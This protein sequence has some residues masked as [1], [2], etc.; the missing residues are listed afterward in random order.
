MR[1]TSVLSLCTLLMCVSNSHAQHTPL[2]IV[3]ETTKPSNSENK[4]ISIQELGWMDQSRME[5]EV[6]SVDELAQTKL[7]STL[8]RDLGDLQLLQRL[9]DGKW[10]SRDDYKTQQALGVVLGNVMLADFPN[11][12]EWKIYEDK[13]GRSRALCVKKTA[14]CLFPVTMLSRRMELGSVP[15]VRKIYD[16]ALLLIEKHLP[17]L[18]YDGGIMYRLPRKQ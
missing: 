8:H 14:E 13:I 7:G 15:N 17:K 3:S 11:T 9:V 2:N 4:E 10:I 16:D 12:L 6:A 1:I 18:P 5:Q